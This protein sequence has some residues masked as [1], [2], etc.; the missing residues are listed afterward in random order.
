MSDMDFILCLLPLYSKVFD[1]W[2][3]IYIAKFWNFCIIKNI[4]IEYLSHGI[5]NIYLLLETVVINKQMVWI[6]PVS[7][8]NIKV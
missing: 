1:I 6:W 3:Y 2:Q 4:F 7:C 5:A 8:F